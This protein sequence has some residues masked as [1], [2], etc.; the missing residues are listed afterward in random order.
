MQAKPKPGS[1]AEL[2]RVFDRGVEL[3]RAGDLSQAR[4]RYETVLAGNPPRTLAADTLANLGSILRRQEAFDEAEARLRESVRLSPGAASGHINLGNLLILRQHYEE[5]E[6]C[7]LRA[8]AIQPGETM[9]LY[10]LGL[11]HLGQGRYETGFPLY[12]QRHDRAA[13]PLRKLNF[14]EWD[15]SPLDG[16]S[17]FVWREQGYGDELQMARFISRLKAAG[18]GK[19]TVAPTVALIRLFETL[20][21]VDEVLRLVGDTVVPRHDLWTLPFSLPACLGVSMADASAAPYLRAPDEARERWRGF[22]PKGAVGFVWHGNPAQEVERF[23]GLPSP[24]AL[25]PLA[26]HVELID[27]QEPRG[28]FADTAAIIE[29]LDLVITTDTAMAHLAGAMGRPCWVLLPAVAC[30]WRWLRRRIDSPWYPS[31]RLWRQTRLDDW[32]SVVEAMAQELAAH[33]VPRG[34]V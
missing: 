4:A 22:A 32:G 7:Y 16:R 18:A 15:G 19:V 2:R 20:E 5:A 10:R 34:G 26:R 29:Q 17:V 24:D 14:P 3:H 31:L 23:R 13:T 30:D 1:A 11:A 12:E 8:L 27:L 21:G 28:D 6:A 33:G 25:R 9:Q